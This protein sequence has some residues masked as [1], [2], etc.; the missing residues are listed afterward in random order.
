MFELI[1]KCP[2]KYLKIKKITVTVFLKM[3]FVFKK[4]HTKNS[5][6]MNVCLAFCKIK[7]KPVFD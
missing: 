4:M 1:A 5:P 2:N 6:F 7:H 3:K